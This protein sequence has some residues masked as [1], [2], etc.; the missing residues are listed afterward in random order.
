MTEYHYSVIED[1]RELGGTCS[2]Q[3]V[4]DKICGGH[5]M[6]MGG[7]HPFRMSKAGS[8]G[9]VPHVPIIESTKT[10]KGLKHIN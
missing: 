8:D 10:M 1:G 5:G 2:C 7:P 9:G 3:C 6:R 4:P